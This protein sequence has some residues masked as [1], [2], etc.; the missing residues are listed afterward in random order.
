MHMA[1]SQPDKLNVLLRGELA[2]IETYKQALDKVDRAEGGAEL[3]EI[4]KDHIDAAN[5]LRRHVHQMGAQPDLASGAWGAFAKAVEGA[6]KLF[7][8][9]AAIKA[10]KEG[11]ESGLKAYTEAANDASLPT[12][13]RTL[14]TS[15]LLPQTRAH[16]PVLDRL[17]SKQ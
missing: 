7:G 3:K 6:A 8:N 14:I 13:C 10:L 9:T 17:M 11:E 16:I 2:A 5:S 1:T 15:T 12:E 4:Q